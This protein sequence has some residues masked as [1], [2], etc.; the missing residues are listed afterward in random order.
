MIHPRNSTGSETVGPTESPSPRHPVLTIVVI[1]FV[2]V[3]SGAR[4]SREVRA[5]IEV[6]RHRGLQLIL[7]ATLTA[8]AMD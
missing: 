3:S 6:K 4:C 2:L 5:A 7:T 1:A 8:M